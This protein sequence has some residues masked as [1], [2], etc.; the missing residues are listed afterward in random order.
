[1]KYLH[2]DP[3]TCNNE[4]DEYDDYSDNEYWGESEEIPDDEDMLRNKYPGFG[5]INT[6][7]ETR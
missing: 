1:M 2:R 3:S 4:G 6:Q 5:D 7:R